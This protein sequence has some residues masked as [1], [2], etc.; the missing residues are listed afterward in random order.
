MSYI[1]DNAERSSDVPALRLHHRAY[2][3]R[4]S[5]ETRHFYEDIL[6]M[7]FAHAME[8]RNLTATTGEVVDFLHTFF[9]LADGSYIAFFDLG[10]GKSAISDADTPEFSTR[11]SMLVSGEEG[12]QAVMRRLTEYN[13]PFEGPVE[14]QG[15]LRSIYLRDPNGIRIEFGYEIADAKLDSDP[16][17]QDRKGR[18]ILQNWVKEH[19][20]S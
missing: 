9:E 2:K 19:A 6:E 7:P 13:V 17:A 5:E 3:C 14:Q 12:L 20:L 15:Y 4:N 11:F 18:E 1:A 8:V 16:K 10:D